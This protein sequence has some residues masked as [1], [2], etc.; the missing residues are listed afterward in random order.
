MQKCEWVT[1]IANAYKVININTYN[2]IT[3]PL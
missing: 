3:L 1:Q 2:M